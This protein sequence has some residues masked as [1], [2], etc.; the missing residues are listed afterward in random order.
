MARPLRLRQL[1][2]L[3]ILNAADGNGTAS[4]PPRVEGIDEETTIEVVRELRDQGLLAGS[5]FSNGSTEAD[6]G[7]QAVALTDEGRE[8]RRLLARKHR[9]A[10][11]GT[12]ADRTQDSGSRGGC[13]DD[14]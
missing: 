11:G 12:V 3:E 2:Q 6:S 7:T 5:V 13:P 10:G 4:G 14:L 9:R 1:I 8:Y